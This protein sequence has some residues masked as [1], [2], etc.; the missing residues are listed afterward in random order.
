MAPV[1]VR[2]PCTLKVGRGSA[3]GCRGR[4]VNHFQGDALLVPHA[5]VP[6]VISD[7]LRPRFIKDER[8]ESCEGF[9]GEEE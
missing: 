3:G 5:Y 4:P 7:E 6:R 9:L 1:D 2:M 8:V